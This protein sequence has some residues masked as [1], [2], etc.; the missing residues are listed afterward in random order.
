MNHPNIVTIH[1]VEEAEGI[2]FITMEYVDGDTLS[3]EI[4][5]GGMPLLR[6]RSKC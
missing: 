4:V 2:H 1:L 6:T 3:S 5:E